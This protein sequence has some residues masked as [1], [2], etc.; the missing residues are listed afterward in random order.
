MPTDCPIRGMI[1]TIAEIGER[2][3]LRRSTNGQ[4]VLPPVLST[5]MR[6]HLGFGSNHPTVKMAI[7][8]LTHRPNSTL[9]HIRQRCFLTASRLYERAR[10]TSQQ[11]QFS[12]R[13]ALGVNM[14][15]LY[16]LLLDTPDS[17]LSD[18]ET[19][20]VS[21]H[22]LCRYLSHGTALTRRRFLS[23]WRVR[24]LPQRTA[25]TAS[26]SLQEAVVGM[27]REWV[28][29]PH[30][31]HRRM[32][33]IQTQTTGSPFIKQPR[34][35]LTFQQNGMRS[36]EFKACS[37]VM[38]INLSLYREDREARLKSISQAIE[39]EQVVARA[40][41]GLGAFGAP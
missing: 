23:N 18:W 1:E 13:L 22:D 14:Y 39:F 26:R 16:E 10:M 12:R 35:T 33:F 36:L 25:A 4:V 3:G 28:N 2:G 41:G 32:S 40:E 24:Y 29:S 7:A 9:E 31:T 34:N 8:S 6:E 20:A 21:P 5:F 37:H 19:T 38:I 27:F 30:A 15:G 11:V 17:P